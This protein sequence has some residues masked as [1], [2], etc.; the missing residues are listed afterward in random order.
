MIVRCFAERLVCLIGSLLLIS[1]T[2]SGQV[3]LDEF[4]SGFDPSLNWQGDL[5][6]FVGNAGRLQL[7]DMRPT[8]TSNARVW[9]P[10]NTQNEA[11]WTLDAE[12]QFSPSASNKAVWWL[13]AD[14]PLDQAGIQGYFLQ[15]GGISGG[16][17]AYELFEV[18]GNSTNLILSGQTGGAA[19]DPVIASLQVCRTT[20]GDWDLEVADAAGSIVDQATGSGTNPLAGAFAGLILDFT[21]TRN[22]LFFF[23]NFSID[24]IF[25]DQVAPSLVS[26][27]AIDERTIEL[28]AS[29]SLSGTAAAAGNYQVG[30]I[31]VA[32]ATLNGNRVELTLASAL[33]SGQSTPLT[34]AS[35]SDQAGNEATNLSSSV[36]FIAP[37]QLAAFELLITELMPDPTP[38]IGL[39]DFEYIE[40]FNAGS[41]AIDLSTVSLSDDGALIELPAIMLDA[42]AYVAFAR[43]AGGDAR[44]TTFP[45]FPT[46]TNS[47]GLLGLVFNGQTIDQVNYTPSWHEPSKDDG[48]YSLERRDLNQP[49][50]L[51]QA[52][53]SSSASLSGGTPG[54]A[55]S[56]A[57]T[58]V[59]DSLN[60]TG[61]D[62]LGTST[63]LVSTNRVLQ[64]ATSAFQFSNGGGYTVSSTDFINEYL[65]ELDQPLSL[66]DSRVLLLAPGASSCLGSDIISQLGVTVGIPDLPEVGDWELNEIMYDPLSR[67]GRWVELANVSDKLLS[68]SGLFLSR[69]NDDGTV[70]ELFEPL[71][72]ILVPPGGFVVYADDIETLGRQFPTALLTRIVPTDV[73]TLGSEECLQLFDPVNE[74]V[75]FTV[76]Y[77]ED[78]HNQ[79]YANTDGVSL[80]RIDLTQLP[81]NASNWTSAA[82]TVDFATPTL[83][84]SQARVGQIVPEGTFA[85]VSD[86]ISP[87][88]DGFDDLLILDYTFGEPGV[89]ARFE[90]VDL[91]G[92]S[93]LEA[94]Q[95]TSPGISGTFTWDGVDN[96]GDLAEVG[97]Y[98]LR[99]TYFSPETAKEVEHIAFSLLL[100]R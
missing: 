8:P 70:G 64:D 36:T 98:V 21:S 44:F 63:L 12:L 16:D 6:A 90:I 66:G 100:R 78:W 50:L 84:N 17:D 76:C 74:E 29:E 2:L 24:P 23:D 11:C 3:L 20:S 9:L 85:L 39:P 26:A 31:V 87:D 60:I 10:A 81:Q 30:G 57:T 56:I 48:G 86:V 1:A 91:L 97:T 37:R 99:I 25:I 41:D 43:D 83:P 40:L 47:G 22:G 59:G 45:D 49:C 69:Q 4:T 92:R 46:L 94:N 38:A 71:S 13:A 5:D 34:I 18:V 58:I 62:V 53:W 68:T 88:G 27:T 15:L 55:N 82:A 77:T 54:A 35:W 72:S 14:R 89:L 65:L 19:N 79:A 61:V 32:N 52:N 96:D 93:V 73:P 51:G 42:Q 28:I 33:V 75:Y 95:D 67:Q 7:N 80:E